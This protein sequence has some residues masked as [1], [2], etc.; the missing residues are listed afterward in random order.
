MFLTNTQLSDFFLGVC[1]GGGVVGM[2]IWSRIFAEK[3]HVTF[4]VC[5]RV[6]RGIR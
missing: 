6:D 3:F 4:K 1:I 2:D 5:V